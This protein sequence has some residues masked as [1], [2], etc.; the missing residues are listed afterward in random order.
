MEYE[1]PS[2]PVTVTFEA[3][4]AV[5]VKVEELPELTEAGLAL[6]LTVGVPVPPLLKL[7]PHPVN[8][9]RSADINIIANDEE[10]RL[11]DRLARSFIMVFSPIFR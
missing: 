2:V 7:R 10:I 9:R 5:T 8:T 6:M 11:T 4:A 3:F 1:L